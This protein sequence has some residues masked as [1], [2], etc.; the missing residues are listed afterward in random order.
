MSYASYGVHGELVVTQQ[1]GVDTALVP[2]SDS[3][4][5]RFGSLVV[6]L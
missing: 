3:R 2:K 1:L 4:N 5:A 6:I